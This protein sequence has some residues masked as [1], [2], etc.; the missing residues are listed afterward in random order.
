VLKQDENP[1]KEFKLAVRGCVKGHKKL[2]IEMEDMQDYSSAIQHRS[3]VYQLL[4][5]ENRTVPACQQKVKIAYLL[6]AMDEHTK[7]TVELTDTIRRLFRGV[8]SQDLM[9]ADRSDLLVQCYQMRAI[10]YAKTKKWREALQEY[11]LLLPLI[12]RKEG[13]GGRDYNSA[14]IHKA[15]LLVTMGKYGLA[16][17]TI[18]AYLQLQGL[19]QEVAGNLIVD[20][21]DH[22]LALDVYAATQLKLGKMDAAISTFEGKLQFV[23]NLPDNDK[24]KSDTLHKLGCLHANR[25]HHKKAL[26]LLNEA[27][28]SKKLSYDGKHKSVLETTWAF[29]ATNHVLGNNDKAVKEY[30]TLLEKMKNVD[31]MPVDSHLIHN[32]AGKLF[33]EDGKLDM[34]IDSFNQA[35]KGV[36][37]LSNSDLKAQISLN[38]ANALSAKGEAERAMELY[39]GILQTKALKKTKI[40]FLARFNQS[41]LLIKTGDVKEGKAILR[42]VAE[43]RTPNAN[44][45]KG[46]IFLTLGNLTLMDGDTDEALSYFEKSL[47]V[48]SDDD[49]SARAQAKRCTAMSY[50]EA[51]D[52]EEAIATLEDILEDLSHS[53]V[54]GKSANLLKA[55]MWN[56]MAQVYKKQLD[57]T[58]AI[59]FSKL[60]LQTYTSEMGETSPITLRNKSNLQLLQLEVAEGLE[61]PEAKPLIDIA[62]SELETT[63]EA[64]EA[65]NDPWTYRLDVVS[66]K[67]NLGFVAVWQGK[68]KKARKL[69][70]QIEEIELSPEDP[71]VKRITALEERVEELERKKGKR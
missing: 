10:C 24:M 50:L 39:N 66:L 65:L 17:S 37:A 23:K 14:V 60:A 42:K 35:L 2:A 8:A 58:Q 28:S 7:S 27:L 5:E 1:G 30:S 9:P 26:P 67:T 15:A 56:S 47:N 22:V 49:F 55:E 18:D 51:G 33:F 71:L 45:V 25:H 40:F 11:D 48:A 29:A 13:E 16:A 6:G 59:K 53:N 54:K 20:D 43:A 41:L 31:D 52:T 3:R 12:S 46:S 62:K 57:L 4:D 64:F 19:T 34:A 68:P 38:L 21:L 32:S 36:N 70:R 69:L 63:L 44:A 61:P